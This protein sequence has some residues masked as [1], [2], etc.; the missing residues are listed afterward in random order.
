M[1]TYALTCCSTADLTPSWLDG[2]GVRYV[3]F[4][5]EL[6]GIP[7]KD[8]FGK[9]HAPKELYARM[10]KG[11]TVKT[12]Q[13]SIGEYMEFWA[14]LL[15]A[16]QDV[17]HVTLSSG[18]SGTYGSACAARD[19]LRRVFPERRLVVIDSLCASSGYGLLVDRMAQLRS[20]GMGLDDLASWATIHRLEVQHWFFSSDLSFFVRGGRIS[21]V[22]GVVG[23]ML[24]ICPVMNVEADGALA[25]KEK[26]RTKGKAERRVVALMHQLAR[27]GDDYAGK[28][29]ICNADCLD[30]ARAVSDMIEA[31]FPKLDGPVHHFDV[32]ATIG[33]HTGPGTVALFFWGAPG[34]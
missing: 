30:D 20:A 28:A 4:N 21:K 19:A 11:A 8:D 6:D 24:K 16:G 1:L 14:P 13:V 9:T 15:E 27:D 26:I 7:C 5:Y 2:I 25:V 22:A 34:T 18:I 33:C 12:S 31:Q 10:L 23:G 17:L 32:G 29:F 3:F